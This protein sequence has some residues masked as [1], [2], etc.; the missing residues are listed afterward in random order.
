MKSHTSVQVS[1]TQDYLHIAYLIRFLKLNLIREN[2]GNI[3]QYTIY[4]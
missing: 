4:F 1:S 3:T 2:V